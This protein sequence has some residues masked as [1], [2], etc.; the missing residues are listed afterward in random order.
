MNSNGRA[1]PGYQ[2]GTQD[3]IDYLTF[4]GTSIG[5]A[6]TDGSVVNLTTSTSN[7]TPELSLGT[8]NAN[9]NLVV[10][11]GL[12]SN[13]HTVVNGAVQIISPES[14]QNNALSIGFE[15][16]PDSE[17]Y[18]SYT[19]GSIASTSITISNEDTASYTTNY[20]SV[21]MNSNGQAFLGYQEGTQDTIDYLTFDGTSI[22]LA[23][24]DGSVVNLTTSTGNRTPELSIGT[25]KANNNLV[26]NGAL[27]ISTLTGGNIL[28]CNDD[29]PPQVLSTNVPYTAIFSPSY[30]SFYSTA[31]NSYADRELLYIDSVT[32]NTADID[33]TYA[34]STNTS[35]TVGTAGCYEVSYTVYVETVPPVG[36]PIILQVVYNNGTEI[37]L[38][39]ITATRTSGV[40]LSGRGI[41]ELLADETVSIRVLTPG[42]TG[43]V[44]IG[45]A[46]PVVPGVS[47]YI[48]RIA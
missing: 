15:N 32:N 46:T 17:V 4:D 35:I 22:G 25:S 23:T 37:A 9:N 47:L 18:M 48:H 34:G 6:T 10:N 14:N 19:P 28:Y 29:D 13:G 43:P 24:T 30:G 5:L 21:G 12:T 27:A 39:T 38:D 45:H 31:Q 20:L 26:V 1:F 8:T 16:A 36:L 33:L 40:S 42:G 41:I 7:G 11:G 44:T 3:T 2:E